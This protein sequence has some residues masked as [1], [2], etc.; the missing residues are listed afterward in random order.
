M[1]IGLEVS[2]EIIPLKE[3][4]QHE[5][6]AVGGKAYHLGKIVGTK[7]NVPDGFVIPTVFFEEHLQKI[8]ELENDSE[9]PQKILHT[10]LEVELKEKILHFYKTMGE[11]LVAVRSS[12]IAEDLDSASFA[13]QYET[14]LGIKGKEALLKAI[15]KCWMSAFAA[16]VEHYK[17]IQDIKE[18]IPKMAVIVQRMVNADISGVMFTV[19]PLTGRDEEIL[20][21]SCWGLGE[22][23]VSGELSPDRFVVNGYQQKI[24]EKH[25]Q[26]KPFKIHLSDTGKTEKIELSSEEQEQQSLSDHKLLQLAQ[27]GLQIQ[28]H[29]GK[30]LDI[31]WA[32]E[33]D[34]IYILQVR[35]IT[36]LNFA[37]DFGQW[38]TANLREVY[39]PEG[40]K[41]YSRYFS[42]DPF[43]WEMS[44]VLRDIKL[45]KKNDPEPEWYTEFFSRSYWN[46]GAIKKLV[47]RIPGYNERIFD[48]NAGIEPYYEGDGQ[49]T[50]WTLGTII[51]AIP[52]LLALN[53]Q[54]KEYPKIAEAHLKEFPEKETYFA[55][56]AKKLT[57]LPLDEFYEKYQEIVHYALYTNQIAM[58]VGFLGALIHDDF[59]PKIENINK[60]LPD[61]QKIEVGKLLTGLSDIKT[62]EALL[63]L[64]KLA[65]EIMA[66]E[67]ARSIVIN[68]ETKEIIQKLK[69]T[70]ETTPFAKKLET[71]VSTYAYITAYDEE[72]SQPRWGDQPWLALELLKHYVSGNNANTIT[73]E[74]KLKQQEKER[75]QEEEKVRKLLKRGFFG[76][77]IGWYRWKSFKHELRQLQYYVYLREATRLP[78]SKIFYHLRHFSLELARRWKEMGYIDENDDLF[79]VQYHTV[80]KFINNETTLEELRKELSYRKLKWHCFKNFDAPPTITGNVSMTTKVQETTADNTTLKGVGCSAGIVEGT[81]RII[82]KLED[83]EALQKGEILV[84]KFTNP[85]WT[86]LFALAKGIILEEGGLLSHGAVVAREVGI[87]AVLQIRNATK[88][89]KNGDYVKLDG[90]NGTVQ[91]LSH[92][93]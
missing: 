50:P 92:S 13:G 81:V 52:V 17:R 35:P 11:P 15:K 20:I 87:P 10:E 40:I 7:V 72:L 4:P 42:G 86:P 32:I 76:K 71:Y 12:A 47:S 46:V 88:I 84:T 34:T 44:Q 62:S 73:P 68:T 1:I 59:V 78:V 49:T 21:E 58:H 9:I 8:D 63:S 18:H 3:I 36:K 2:K 91:L 67:Q 38:T 41:P 33:K 19:N 70:K 29:Y 60:K 37:P 27:L 30:P 23:V 53:K 90:T 48:E 6:N 5:K 39:P 75:V 54:L 82:L 43:R 61:D 89:L 55:E 79:Y 22:A 51:R 69:D 45:M 56:L 65:T 80:L 74:E 14:Y 66:N 83:G 85:G 26:K 64:W 28:A 25:I 57:E 77:L 31:E 16:R 93:N 24:L